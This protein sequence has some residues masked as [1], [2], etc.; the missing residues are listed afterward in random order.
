MFSV[1]VATESVDDICS[2]HL[3]ETLHNVQVQ[4]DMKEDRGGLCQYVPANCNKGQAGAPIVVCSQS[5][6]PSL[7]K[8]KKL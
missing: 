1:V 4:Y 7:L 2:L 3:L 5:R 6:Y 8:L